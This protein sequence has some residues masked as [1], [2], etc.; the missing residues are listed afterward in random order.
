MKFGYHLIILN[1]F[2]YS[3]VF[4]F[5]IIPL[6]NAVGLLLLL[7]NFYS[8]MKVI[9]YKQDGISKLTVLMCLMFVS[10]I[11]AW[12]LSPKHQIGT[13]GLYS[14]SHIMTGTIVNLSTILSSFY[15]CRKSDIPIDKLY[16]VGLLLFVIAIIGFIF[17]RGQM[18]VSEYGWGMNSGYNF[19]FVLLML[20]VKGFNRKTDLFFLLTFILVVISAKRGAMVCMAVMS[21]VY[22]LMRYKG[23]FKKSIIMIPFFV[24]LLYGL[25]SYVL[26]NDTN[27]QTKIEV[28]KD[29]DTSGREYINEVLWLHWLAS[30]NQEKIFGYQFAGSVGL[31]GMDAHNDWLEL[32]TGQGAVGVLL[33]AAILISLLLLYWRRRKY[34]EPHEQFIIVAGLL[35]WIVKSVGSQTL[36]GEDTLVFSLLY[37]FVIGHSYLQKR[38]A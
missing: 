38:I 20:I 23:R 17:E 30:S 14:T 32:L 16:K 9:G 35:V 27:L 10:S 24:L 6:N 25:F 31:L 4:L 26:Q 1:L 21:I 12:A 29:G 11:A 37:G 33:Y 13:A 18:E 7:F 3:L 15:I 2:L 19:L 28:T 8:V 22:V 34:L 5:Q 36:Y